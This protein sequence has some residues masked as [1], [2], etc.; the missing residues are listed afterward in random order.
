MMNCYDLDMT[1]ITKLTKGY[2]DDVEIL[3]YYL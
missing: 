1:V 2:H 3:M